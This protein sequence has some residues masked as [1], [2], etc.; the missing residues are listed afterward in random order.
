MKVSARVDMNPAPID[1]LDLEVL[2]GRGASRN[3]A[4]IP[5]YFLLIQRLVAPALLV[6]VWVG[7]AKFF[8]GPFHF[9]SPPV[10]SCV[11]PP[12]FRPRR[13]LPF[14][15]PVCSLGCLYLI[16]CSLCQVLGATLSHSPRHRNYTQVR[17]AL[18]HSNRAVLHVNVGSYLQ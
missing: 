3:I 18:R 17:L 7:V 10:C 9:P 1:L 5:I 12:F 14:I 4:S 16:C 15:I 11:F 13:P 8:P 6:S 2:R